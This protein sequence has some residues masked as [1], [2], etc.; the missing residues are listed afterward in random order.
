MI[1]DWDPANNYG[2]TVALSPVYERLAQG[3]WARGPAGTNE[4][5]FAH[6]GYI[7]NELVKGLLAENWEQPDPLTL[8]V[9][10]RK[11]VRF[12]NVTPVNGREMT[13]DDVVYSYNRLNKSTITR[14]QMKIVDYTVTESITATD[15]YTVVWK[16]SRPYSQTVTET[17]LANAGFIH[18]H[19]MVEAGNFGDWR[20][21][22]GTGP[23]TL[24]DFVADSSYVYK[25]NPNYWGYDELNP[26]NRLPYVDTVRNM[27]IIDRSTQLAALRTGKLDS[28]VLVSPSEAKTLETA[29]QLK[30]TDVLQWTSC[31]AV[32][33]R[34]DVQPFSDIRVRQAMS[35]AID[36][37]GIIRDYLGGKGEIINIPSLANY[38][39]FYTPFDELPKDIREIYSYNPEKARQLLAAAGYTTGFE[40]E[41]IM[42]VAE[43]DEQAAILAG[44]W[45]TIGIHV[46]YKVLEYATLYSLRSRRDY[47]KMLLGRMGVSDPIRV[48]STWKSD[49]V[50]NLAF[51]NDP[52]YDQMVGKL[53]STVDKP[54]INAAVKECTEYLLR[55]VWEIRFPHGYS[56]NYYQPWL[57]NYHGEVQL[58]L[59]DFGGIFA[60]VWIDQDLKKSISGR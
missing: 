42:P 38:G 51:A 30:R 31:P 39:E 52:V 34:C 32:D 45:E 1:G 40:V 44:Y 5:N 57:K 3:D 54:S 16:F 15:K 2:C 19:E 17:L 14:S 21:V 8:I 9:H 29:T 49:S 48:C 18:P 56:Y 53:L 27:V 10:L 37:Q 4:F 6:Y 35:M 7:P 33:M 26:K 24:A 59:Y 23:F 22:C 36:Y 50:G 47:N 58:G 12:H 25:R 11:G 55:Q 60:R 28:L 43:F 41:A 20:N 13:A 46:K